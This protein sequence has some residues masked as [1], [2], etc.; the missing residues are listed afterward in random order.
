[1]YGGRDGG[2]EKNKGNDMKGLLHTDLMVYCQVKFFTYVGHH[3]KS[4][5]QIRI[6]IKYG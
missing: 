2:K 1:V 3:P 6:M 4:G 5:Q